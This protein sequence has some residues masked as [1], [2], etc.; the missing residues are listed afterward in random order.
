M[1]MGRPLMILHKFSTLPPSPLDDDK[2]Q[3]MQSLGLPAIGSFLEGI[4][5]SDTLGTILTTIYDQNIS[6]SNMSAGNQKH[7]QTPTEIDTVLELD[8]KLTKFQ[9]ELPIELRWASEGEKLRQSLG[10][11]V[12]NLDMQSNALHAR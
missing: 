9:N 2:P 12:G 3:S 4:K 8:K 7:I 11:S 6:N 10:P 5:L 1:A